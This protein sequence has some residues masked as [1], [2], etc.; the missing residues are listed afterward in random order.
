MDAAI[1]I[2][3]E[4]P[5]D[6][7][8]RGDEFAIGLSGLG[9]RPRR[10]VARPLV[11]LATLDGATPIVSQTVFIANRPF[12]HHSDR[13]ICFCEPAA[14]SSASLRSRLP[15]SF[16]RAGAATRAPG[17]WFCSSAAREPRTLPPPRPR[18]PS[19]SA[20]PERPICASGRVG[21]AEPRCQGQQGSPPRPAHRSPRPSPASEP[22]SIAVGA[23]VR[24]G[25]QSSEKVPVI[26]MCGRPGW[27]RRDR[28]DGWRLIG[29]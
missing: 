9:G 11:R 4:F 28:Y 27:R 14:T 26:D 6:L 3:G 21:S 22:S 8:N 13:N 5:D 12:G 16:C 15:S 20:R 23:L 18:Q 19:P 17:S 7:F 25:P 10:T 24:S 1:A 29:S 2:G